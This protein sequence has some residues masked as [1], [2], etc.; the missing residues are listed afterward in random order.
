MSTIQTNKDIKFSYEILE[1]FEAGLVLTGAEVKSVKLG[2]VQLKGSYVKI[3]KNSIS[4]WLNWNEKILIER[5]K[6]RLF[7]T[8]NIIRFLSPIKRKPK[9]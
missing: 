2:H 3:K 1:K 6:N 5:I 9:M 4:F 8:R 7:G